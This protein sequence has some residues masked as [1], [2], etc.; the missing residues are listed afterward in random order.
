ML[1]IKLNSTDYSTFEG[2][3]VQENRA[4]GHLMTIVSWGVVD[5]IEV[6]GGD[7]E[8]PGMVTLFVKTA[9]SSR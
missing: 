8:N 4:L 1:G 6:S 7:Y 2:K 9:A 3:D 5:L